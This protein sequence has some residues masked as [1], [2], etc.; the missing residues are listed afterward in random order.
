MWTKKV[1]D[2]L[3]AEIPRASTKRLQAIYKEVM[4]KDT[5]NRNA[6]ALR[7]RLLAWI[8]KEGVLPAPEQIAESI[9]RRARDKRAAQPDTIVLAPDV[10]PAVLKSA[11]RKTVSTK[12]RNTKDVLARLAVGQVLQ[13]RYRGGKSC[14]VTV[15]RPPD[16]SGQ[17][18]RFLYGRLEY[19]NLR[20]I[21]IID[22]GHA[23][24]VLLFFRLA[25]YPKHKN[26]KR[27]AK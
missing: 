12:R 26:R 4:K 27:V 18:G 10:A 17:G 5:S 15:L 11:A 8:D 21:A 13:H 1:A 24:N 14:E 16:T 22:S 2:A 19:D 6:A 7:T 20:E 23:W 25:P 9:H 3:R